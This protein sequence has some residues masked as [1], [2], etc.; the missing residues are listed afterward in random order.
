MRTFLYFS[1]QKL[2]YLTDSYDKAQAADF[3]WEQFKVHRSVLMVDQYPENRADL[4]RRLKDRSGGQGEEECPPDSP[5][6]Q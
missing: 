6:A 4:Y 2:E 5:F 3:C 1:G